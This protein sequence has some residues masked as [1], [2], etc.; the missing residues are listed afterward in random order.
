M[1]AVRLERSHGAK[2]WQPCRSLAVAAC[3]GLAADMSVHPT[4][5]ERTAPWHNQFLLPSH[6]PTHS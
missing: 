2:E 1:F 3:I 4:D 6:R 5:T